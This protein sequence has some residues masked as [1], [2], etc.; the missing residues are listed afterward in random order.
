MDSIVMTI[1]T[2]NFI[3][4]IKLKLIRLLEESDQ[5]YAPCTLPK[6]KDDHY[7][8]EQKTMPMIVYIYNLFFYSQKTNE[9]TV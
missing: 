9:K 1:E 2:G 8:K 3:F 6:C 5:T 4:R 7:R